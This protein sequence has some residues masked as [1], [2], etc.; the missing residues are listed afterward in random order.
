MRHEFGYR[1]AFLGN[2]Q[3]IAGPFDL[4][5]Q[6]QAFG[7]EFRSTRLRTTIQSA[8]YSDQ[9]QALAHQ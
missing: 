7:L 2:H 5:Q 3:A 1:L 6:G 8:S 4:I 9:L